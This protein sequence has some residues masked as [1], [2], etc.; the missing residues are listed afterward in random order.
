MDIGRSSERISI[1]GNYG[2]SA[3]S[4][5]EL[6]EKS[7][8]AEKDEVQIKEKEC[9]APDFEECCSPKSTP[10]DAPTLLPC[11]RHESK[12]KNSLFG[13]LGHEELILIGL[14]LLLSQSDCD[15]DIVF[16][17]LFLLLF[18]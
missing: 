14:I 16:I 18:K 7:S 9:S 15:N 1:P 13:D 11:P 17:L 5:K 10:S 2:G 3:F 8:E 6:F 12:A 4:E